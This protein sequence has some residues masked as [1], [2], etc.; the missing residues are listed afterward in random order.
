MSVC[1][2]VCLSVC[3]HDNYR[4][5]RD[6]IT[7]FLGHHP[8]VE[9]A[10]KFESGYIGVRG[11]CENVCDFLVIVWVLRMSCANCNFDVLRWRSIVVRPPVL[12]GE[13]CTR[14]MAGRVTTLW[15]KRPLSVNNMDN[16][17]SHP[18]GVG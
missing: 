14:L 15:L 11:W 7:K 3:Q 6:I 9:T 17:A 13:L 18:S 4:T 12:A 10:D 8:I 16:S 2:C 1:V 5:V